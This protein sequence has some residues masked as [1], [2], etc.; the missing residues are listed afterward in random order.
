[1]PPNVAFKAHERALGQLFSEI[2]IINNDVL[3]NDG[4][5]MPSGVHVRRANK[6]RIG[7]SYWIYYRVY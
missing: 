3:M 1:M 7:G 6:E 5:Y 4:I 2:V